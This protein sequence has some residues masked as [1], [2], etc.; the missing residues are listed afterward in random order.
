MKRLAVPLRLASGDLPI[1]LN[2][3][4]PSVPRPPMGGPVAHSVFPVCPPG[5]APCPRLPS[6]LKRISISLYASVMLR[7]PT[8]THLPFDLLHGALKAAGEG[9]RLR[10]LALLAD[11]E[12]TV[13]DLTT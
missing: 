3:S 8:S 7:M 11:A 13:S 10:I 6:P 1:W 5:Q 9:T 2:T 12:L 4:T